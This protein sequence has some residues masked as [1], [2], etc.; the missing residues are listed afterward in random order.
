MCVSG[1][2]GGGERVKLLNE[3]LIVEF[4]VDVLRPAAVSALGEELRPFSPVRFCPNQ[5]LVSVP[6]SFQMS[7]LAAAAVSSV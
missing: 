2:G 7:D 1:G 5:G 4:F 6:L 3:Q